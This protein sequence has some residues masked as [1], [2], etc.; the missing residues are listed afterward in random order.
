[1]DRSPG[2]GRRKAID[3]GDLARAGSAVTDPR[4]TVADRVLH[5][6]RRVA[7]PTMRGVRFVPSAIPDVV[8]IEPDVHRDGR[9]FFVE[10]Y[11]A[12]ALRDAAIDATFVQDN[13]SRS[14]RG[15]LRGLHAQLA[16]PQGKLVR[17]VAGEVFDVAV[18]LRRASPTYLR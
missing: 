1:M 6:L 7:S 9:G 15:T 4:G 14:T 3:G 8:R 2:S 16:P 12:D 13:H 5:P 17:V 18:D 11:R 10:T